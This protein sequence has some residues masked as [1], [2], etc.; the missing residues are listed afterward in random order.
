MLAEAICELGEEIA[1]VIKPKEHE[2]SHAGEEHEHL[3]NGHE[4]VGE[5]AGLL[6][7]LLDCAQ[8]LDGPCGQASEG[9]DMVRVIRNC[10]YTLVASLMPVIYSGFHVGGAELKCETER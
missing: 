6:H 9:M 3:P 7:L 2:E 8:V 1:D 4:G 10:I 5:V